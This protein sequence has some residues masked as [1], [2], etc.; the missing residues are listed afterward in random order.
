MAEVR[1]DIRYDGLDRV[2]DSIDQFLDAIKPPSLTESVSKG[3]DVFVTSLKDA[4][5]VKSGTLRD[6]I[7]KFE[8]GPTKFQIGPR[9]VIYAAIQNHGGTVHSS[10]PGGYLMISDNPDG[11]VYVK[12][13]RI[14]GSHYMVKGFEAGIEPAA[15]AVKVDII[16]KI[17]S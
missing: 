17:N 12:S 9:G 11:P 3:A 15:E 8:V 14:P 13:V 16:T 1:I 5:P 10:R 6:S 7:D 2:Q 4:A